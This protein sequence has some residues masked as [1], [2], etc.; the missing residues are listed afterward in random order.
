MGRK[1]FLG[2]H[3]TI[4][5]EHSG[6]QLSFSELTNE[7]KGKKILKTSGEK[8]EHESHVLLS[9]LENHAPLTELE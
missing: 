1:T 7:S 2:Y 4:S 8:K 5:E 6:S 9:S 3:G